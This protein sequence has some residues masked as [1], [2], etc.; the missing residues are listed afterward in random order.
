MAGC[1]GPTMPTVGPSSPVASGSGSPS[2]STPP[3]PSEP[4]ATPRCSALSVP[5][6]PIV[7]CT[8]L[9]DGVETYSDHA[10]RKIANVDYYVIGGCEGTG[11]LDE[12]PYTVT[13]DDKTV[14]S[15]SINCR[16]GLVT[17]NS[18]FSGMSGQHR[19]A[20]RFAEGV[21]A[22]ASGYADVTTG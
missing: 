14:T 6:L 10:P 21:G 19:V 11:D 9:R 1:A 2:T 22:N 5:T 13:V 16:T 4:G 15:A 7:A 17:K 3:G 12:L 18:A 8:E 20:I